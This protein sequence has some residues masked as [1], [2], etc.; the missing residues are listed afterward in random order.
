M[1]LSEDSRLM[2][3]IVLASGQL[4]P[5]SS[6]SSEVH[7]EQSS[8]DDLA[9]A[10]VTRNC[11]NPA[12]RVIEGVIRE[13]LSHL[14]DSHSIPDTIFFIPALPLTSHGK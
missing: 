8:S 10:D 12:S 6:S 13:R 11:T 7:G 1:S 4:R 14:L 5:L 3:F 2:A 9:N